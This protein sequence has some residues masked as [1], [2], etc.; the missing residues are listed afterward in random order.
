MN[1]SALNIVAVTA[2]IIALLCCAATFIYIRR[3][4]A[5]RALAAAASP[6]AETSQA[7]DSSSPEATEAAAETDGAPQSASP[8]P[9]QAVRPVSGSGKTVVIDAGHQSKANLTKEAIGPGATEKKYSVSGGTRGVATGLAEYQLNLDVSEQLKDEL[10]QR[11]YTVVMVRESNDV[12]ISNSQRA[13]VANDC[14]AD[15][16]I[17][18]HANGSENSSVSG[19]T[20]ICQTS[21]NPY[22]GALYKQ[23]RKLS[24]CVLNAMITATGA[25]NDGVWETDTMSG[26]NWCQVPVTIVEMGYMSNAAEDKLLASAAYQAKLVQGMADGIDAYF[27][28]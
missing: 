6:S 17:R 2:L 9:A 19:I 13:A 28:G 1:K 7:A 16:F 23:S 5:A 14:K 25:K 11:G 8:S 26:I 10:T 3:D 12:D 18:I 22:N 21:A 15:A 27:A 20:T 24:D 4:N